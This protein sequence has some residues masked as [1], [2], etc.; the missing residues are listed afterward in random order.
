MTGSHLH[1]GELNHCPASGKSQHRA[2]LHLY[3]Y[4]KLKAGDGSEPQIRQISAGKPDLLP[5]VPITDGKGSLLTFGELPSHL[6]FPANS[7]QLLPIQLG[8]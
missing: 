2:A 3:R 1:Q 6:E 8:K 7:A 4:S 5:A